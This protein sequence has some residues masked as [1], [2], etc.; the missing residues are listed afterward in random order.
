MDTLIQLLREL[1]RQRFY[2]SLEI[3][4]ESGKVVLVKRI[5]TLKPTQERYGDNRGDASEHRQR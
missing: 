1:E 2:G 4:L 3:K 5:E